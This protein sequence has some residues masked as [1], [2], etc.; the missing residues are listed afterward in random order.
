MR[1]NYDF[2]IKGVKVFASANEIGRLSMPLASRFRK[3]YLPKYS[4]GSSSRSQ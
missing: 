4:R 1:R 3:L 2:R